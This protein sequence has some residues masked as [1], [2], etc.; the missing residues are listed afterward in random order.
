V[1]QLRAVLQRMNASAVRAVGATED[2]FDSGVVFL[3]YRR[4]TS[5]LAQQPAI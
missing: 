2:P 1:V 4:R 3:T 5:G